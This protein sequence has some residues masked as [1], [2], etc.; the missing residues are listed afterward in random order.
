MVL[1]INP[2][3]QVSY[4]GLSACANKREYDARLLS[5]LQ[6]NSTGDPGRLSHEMLGQKTIRSPLISQNRDVVSY[7]SD[8]VA[9]DGL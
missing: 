8:P 9:Y 7:T 4:Q 5:Q 1:F 6:R 3:P 2:A